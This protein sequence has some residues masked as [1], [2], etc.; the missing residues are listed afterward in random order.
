V[1]AGLLA[2]AA[3]AATPAGATLGQNLASVE[4]DR[5]QLKASVTRT[6]HAA[7]T[8]HEMAVGEQGVVREYAAPNGIVFAVTWHTPG[9]PNLKQLLGAHYDELAK[10]V[11]VRKGGLGHFEARTD[12]VAF[13][14]SGRMRSF[15]GGAYLINGLPSGVSVNDIK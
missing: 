14:S 7:Y 15:H 5:L 9:M 1:A 4:V 3:L 2:A 12:Q 6:N 11:A 13:S 8:V 10:P